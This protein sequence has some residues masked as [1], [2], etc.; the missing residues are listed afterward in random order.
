MG[1]IYLNYSVPGS[2]VKYA[3]GVQVRYA[4]LLRRI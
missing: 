1:I 3:G 2:P 4:R